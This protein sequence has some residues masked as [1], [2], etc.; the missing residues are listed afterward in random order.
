MLNIGAAL[1]IKGLIDSQC[2]NSFMLCEEILKGFRGPLINMMFGVFCEE[3]KIQLA[4]KVP[5]INQKLP[6]LIS[7]PHEGRFFHDRSVLFTT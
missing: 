3:M 4:I 1:D 5:E 6:F 2:F 7:M